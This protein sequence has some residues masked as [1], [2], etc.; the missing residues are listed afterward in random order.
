MG[1]N[2]EANLELQP[3]LLIYYMRQEG[4]YFTYQLCGPNVHLVKVEGAKA[5]KKELE[6]FL[7]FSEKS[8]KEMKGA[9]IVDMSKAK[10]LTS[11]EC[12][13]FHEILDSNAKSIMEN[14]TSI[15]YVNTSVLG[16]LVQK[17]RLQLKPLP[18]RSKVFKSVD[19]A[20]SW[21]YRLFL[22]NHTEKVN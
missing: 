8:A 10:V 11:G 19:E 12:L 14:W 16:R 9:M 18:I 21:S 4:K 22:N 3:L 13:R 7:E 1:S 17:G 2:F 15:A 20:V 5:A 6:E